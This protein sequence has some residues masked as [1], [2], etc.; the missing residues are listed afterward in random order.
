MC[1]R[2]RNGQVEGFEQCEDGNRQRGDGCSDVCTIEA[3]WAC[4]SSECKTVCGDALLVG[5]EGC[6]DGATSAGD[7]CGATC[8]IET[9]W[10]CAGQGAGSCGPQCGDGLRKGAEVC[11]DSNALSDDGCSSTCLIEEGWRCSG[12]PSAC[13]VTCGDGLRLGVEACDDSN[14]TPGDGCSPSCTLE[15]GWL[16]SPDGACVCATGFHDC[17]GLCLAD[18]SVGSCGVACMPCD[19]RVNAS[20]TCDGTS[21]GLACNTGYL[22]C[23]A[24]DGNGCECGAPANG[25]ATDG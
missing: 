20:A 21:C 9:G 22:N 16:C 6:D 12:M 23:D 19:V 4:A 17:E 11:D 8:E 1:I 25:R 2:D 10:T 7:G 13:A 24:S 18:R 14:L 3:G 15:D 5:D